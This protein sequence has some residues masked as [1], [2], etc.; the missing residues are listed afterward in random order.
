LN[1]YDWNFS[2]LVPYWHAFLRGTGLTIALSVISFVIGTFIGTWIGAILRSSALGRV[3]YLIND[4]VRALPPLVVIFLVYYFPTRQVFGIT[5]PSAFWSSVIAFSIA[6]AA[7]SADLTRAAVNQVPQNSV[8]AGLSIGLTKRDLWRFV[9]LP[10]LIRQMLPAQIAFF[11]GIVRL[12][13]L[14]SVIGCQEVVFV[15][16]QVSTQAFRSFEPWVVVAIIYIVLILPM[17]FA[18][19]ELERSPWLLRRN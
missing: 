6:Q 7:Y 16:R 19:R 2:V 13:N 10:D 5:S 18:L 9:I 15:A 12:S 3:F 8:L 4:A 17:T 1:G 14:A 11:I